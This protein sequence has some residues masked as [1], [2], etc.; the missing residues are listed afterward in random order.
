MAKWLQLKQK[1]GE[2]S[3]PGMPRVAKGWLT[4]PF[5]NSETHMVPL[6][7]WLFLDLELQMTGW[8]RV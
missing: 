8:R 2:Y 3:L 7:F 5:S 6:L 4:D 1:A